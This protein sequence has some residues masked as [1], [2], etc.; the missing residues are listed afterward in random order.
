[1][2]FFVNFFERRARREERA[3]RIRI[4]IRSNYYLII[5]NNNIDDDDD[6]DDESRRVVVK[7]GRVRRE[8]G[9][10]THLGLLRLAAASLPT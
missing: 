2:F 3:G 4:R 6:D 1:M 7:E 8:G 10:E 9:E 5:S